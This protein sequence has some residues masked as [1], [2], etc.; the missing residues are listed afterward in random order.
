MDD[1]A[2]LADPYLRNWFA[3]T[4]SVTAEARKLFDELTPEQL[5][6]KPAPKVW[7]VAE[8]FQHLTAAAELYHPRIDQA[9]GELPQAPPGTP[10]RA[11]RLQRW[12]IEAIGPQAKRRMKAPKS[13]SPSSAEIDLERLERDF[14]ARQDELAALILRSDGLD[15]NRVAVVSPLLKLLRWTLGEVLWMLTAH[16]ERHL[17][18]ARRLLRAPGFPA[19]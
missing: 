6:W 14:F 19:R 13:L 18:Q 2:A 4:R 5:L 12:F 17:L 8:C 1:A 3:V 15:L 10:L 9:V 7:S 11:R 16:S